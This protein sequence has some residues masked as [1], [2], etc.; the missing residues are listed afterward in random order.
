MGLS[1]V[2]PV[3]AGVGVL[4]L[5]GVLVAF[6]SGARAGSRVARQTRDVS[7]MGTTLTRALGL[8]AVIAGVQWGVVTT[9]TDP[10]AWGVVLGLPAVFAGA[11]LARVFVVTTLD[12]DHHGHRLGGRR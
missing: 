3:V 7:R 8:G 10:L 9:T 1:E 2:D 11:A 4:G 12:P 6:R 5:L